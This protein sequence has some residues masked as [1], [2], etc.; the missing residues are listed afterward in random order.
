VLLVSKNVCT[1]SSDYYVRMEATFVATWAVVGKT[2]EVEAILR[3]Q[4]GFEDDPDLLQEALECIADPTVLR[5]PID[6]D[7]PAEQIAHELCLAFLVDFEIE[8][9]V[10]RMRAR[11]P[12][13]PWLRS[14]SLEDAPG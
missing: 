14:A 9:S 8:E 7:A 5:R 3:G 4:P 11:W 6:R 1:I 2:V 13:A 12:N 10:R